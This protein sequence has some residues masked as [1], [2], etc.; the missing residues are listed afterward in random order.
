MK[1]NSINYASPLR[2]NTE[3]NKLQKKQNPSFGNAVVGL[4]TFIEN[5]G[6]LGEFLTIDTVG[7]MAPRT[8][9]GYLRNRKELGHLN[10]KAG[11]EELVR[12]LL[13]GPAFFYVPLTALTIASALKGKSAKVDT[14]VLNGF[15]NIMKNT[16]VEMQNAVETKKNFVKTVINEAFKDY[17]NEKQLVNELSELMEKNATNK[18]KFVDK[19]KNLFR[20][21]N[22]KIETAAILKEK[23]TALV[24]KLNKAN[25][26]NLDNASV[27]EFGGQKYD[28]ANLF[29]D[30][31]NYL[32][33]FTSKA[34]KSTQEKDTFIEKFHKKAQDLRYA[35]N[36]FAVASLSAFL[37]IIPKLYQT[38]DEFPGSDGLTK[39]KNKETPNANEKAKEVA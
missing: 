30:M 22:E 28:T 11:R 16:T 8:G 20:K 38:G 4:A 32:D 33:D 9:Q 14:K 7:M 26:K 21:D 27:I 18:F 23:A 35:A 2:N 39:G 34:A 19:V 29:G 6:F 37:M 31:K 12:E 36:I 17:K 1:L 10:Y 15:K 5:N 24:T 13:S 25:S 3:H